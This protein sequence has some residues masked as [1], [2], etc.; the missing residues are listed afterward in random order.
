MKKLEPPRWCPKAVATIRG[1][2][3]PKTGELLVSKKGLLEQVEETKSEEVI[4]ETTE[5]PKRQKK[6]VN[7]TK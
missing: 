7:E 2:E 5:K 4:P 1:W 3:N 6:E